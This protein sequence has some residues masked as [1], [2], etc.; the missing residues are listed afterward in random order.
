MVLRQ[1][2]QHNLACLFI[3]NSCAVWRKYY[4]NV[5]AITQRNAALLTA[6][7]MYYQQTLPVIK[8]ISAIVVNVCT[9]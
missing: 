9:R 7:C 8:Y 2:L 4:G 3:K 6:S 1:L 5:F